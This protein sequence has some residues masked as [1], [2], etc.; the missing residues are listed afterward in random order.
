M[1]QQ[2][3]KFEEEIRDYYANEY[4][5]ILNLND[6]K[7]DDIRKFLQSQNLNYQS[8]KNRIVGN[9][10]VLKGE[11]SIS[12]TSTIAICFKSSIDSTSCIYAYLYCDII[13]KKVEYRF[14]CTGPTYRSQD[15]EYRSRIIT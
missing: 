6:I 11:Y 14:I 7:N 5:K 9:I 13:D 12:K 3:E 4:I 8:H 15:G 2:T 10:Q 1:S